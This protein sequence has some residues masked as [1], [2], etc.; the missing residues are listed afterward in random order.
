MNRLVWI[1]AASAA[2]AVLMMV[3]AQQGPV[4]TG[5]VKKAG[6]LPVIAVPDFRGA[7][8]AETLMAAFN[9]TLWRTWRVPAC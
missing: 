3:N 9:Q 2:A 5:N 6:Q 4:F 7:G 8:A 1:L